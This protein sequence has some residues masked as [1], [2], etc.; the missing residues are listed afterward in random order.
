MINKIAKN[1]VSIIS[2]IVLI[3]FVAI[4]LMYVTVVRNFSENVFMNL[5]TGLELMLYLA[6]DIAIIVILK[7][8]Q[9]NKKISNKYV[10]I[11]IM[12][13]S[14]IIYSCIAIAWVKS[15]TVEPV[16]DSRC[17][18]ELAKAFAVGNMDGIRNSEYIEKYHNQ[19]GMVLVRGTIYKVFRTTNYRL[20]QYINIIANVTTFIFLYLTLK[21]LER[22]YKINEIVYWGMML[23]FIPLILLTTYVYG[24]Y[25]GLALSSIGIYFVIGYMENKKIIK[26]I[27][28]AIFMCLAYFTK[29]NYI[30]VIL[31][32]LIYLGLYLLQD[33]QE[34]NKKKIAK[35]FFN[36]LIYFFI[37]VMPVSLVKNYYIKKFEYKE[38]L[39][40]PTSVWIY[41]GMMESSRANGWYGDSV[42]EAWSNT[43]LAH[44]TYPQKVKYRIKEFMTHPVYAVKFYLKKTISG[45]T[46]PY[47]QSLWYNVGWENK[48][49]IM[50]NII[51]SKEYK[52]GEIYQ[53]AIMVLMYIGALVAVVKNRKNLSNELVLLITIFIGGVL[54]HT[55]WEMKSRYTLPYVILLIPVSSIGIQDIVSKISYIG[56]KRNEKNISSNTNVL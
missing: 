38:E 6:I 4:N 51:N 10:K 46:D 18:N 8:F 31:S 17:V 22:K 36:I 5:T 7:L 3:V 45:W 1:I 53:K 21:K 54:F 29:M 23:T 47:F 42:N 33:I 52:I 49:E 14:I 12:I 16:D 43:P 48:D 44:E 56:G 34:K 39:A 27:S 32:I 55:M 24:D 11:T 20:I 28:S 19:I 2:T 35:A 25:I 13:I 26:L 41:M 9:K 37:A 30:I 40:L 15:S 50:N